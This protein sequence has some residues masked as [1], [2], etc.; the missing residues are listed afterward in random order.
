[1]IAG[2]RYGFGKGRARKVGMNKTEAKYAAIL[3][4]REIAG[5]VAFWRY[6]CVK[7]KLADKCWFGVDFF[8]M[9]VDGTIEMHEVK[10]GFIH[11]DG[12]IIKLKAAAAQFPLRFIKATYKNKNTGW[13]YEEI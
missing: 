8:V 2:Q 6:E 9:L 3:R 10:G 1:M 13:I 11:D 4:A 7:F 12:G 5:E